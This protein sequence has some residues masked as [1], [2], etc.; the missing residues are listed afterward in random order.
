MAAPSDF[1]ALIL[2]HGRA[3]NVVTADSLKR[4]GYTGPWY[5]VIDDEDDQEDEYRRIYGDR[6]VRFCK[7]AVAET[8]DQFDLETDRRTIVYARNA[9]FD[10]AKSLGFRYFIELD[11]DYTDFQHRWDDGER[12]RVKSITDLDSVFS[13]MLGFLRASGAATVAMGQGG[14]FIGGRG[15]PRFRERVLRKAMNSFICDTERPFK[16]VGRV[17]E[18]VNTYCVEGM[19]G[20]LF[21]TIVDVMLVQK[22]T[23][24]NAG[25]MSGVYADYGTY[26]KSFYTVMC[27]PS[28]VQVS[29]MGDKH[30]RM[31]HRVDWRHGV[32][33]I[34]SG[35]YRKA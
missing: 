9:S 34:I 4:C 13:L 20:E 18:D 17:N 12:L 10:I 5:I 1:C 29:M 15:N 27:C 30:M 25:G 2:T 31:H 7:S 19:R 35:K 6:V 11:D 28:F 16:F 14:D 23:Q 33:M 21:L 26:V 22:R 8:F 24:V 3:G 32:P